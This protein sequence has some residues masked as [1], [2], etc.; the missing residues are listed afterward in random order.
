MTGFV[1]KKEMANSREGTPTLVN[2]R[3]PANTVCPFRDSC[4]E[5]KNGNC[6][7]TG[8]LHNVPYSC[9]YARLFN[10]IRG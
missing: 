5:S 3:I 1:S 4:N 7:H 8:L 9:G 2:G 10:L 6:G